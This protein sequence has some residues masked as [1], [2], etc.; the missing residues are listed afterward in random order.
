MKKVFNLQDAFALN[1]PKT[2]DY[3]V[4]GLAQPTAYTPSISFLTTSSGWNSSATC[5]VSGSVANVRC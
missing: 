1:D 4:E 5:L 3:M 2:K